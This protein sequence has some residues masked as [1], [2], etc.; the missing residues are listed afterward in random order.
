MTVMPQSPVVLL[1]L[2]ELPLDEGVLHD[3]LRVVHQLLRRRDP[4]L[5]TRRRGG[6][7]RQAAPAVLGPATGAVVAGSGGGLEYV[8][9]EFN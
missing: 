9:R 7:D 6:A 5:L 1:L 3:L 8:S 2:L 4:L